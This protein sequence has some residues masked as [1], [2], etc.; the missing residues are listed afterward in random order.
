M[1]RKENGGKTSKEYLAFR[2][3]WENRKFKFWVLALTSELEE[4]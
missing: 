3:V 1:L 4:I 2:K